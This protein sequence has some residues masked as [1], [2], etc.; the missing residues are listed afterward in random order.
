MKAEQEALVQRVRTALATHPSTREVSMFGTRSFMVDDALVVGALKDGGLL[1][2]VNPDR[3]EELGQVAGASRAE[4]GAGRSMG[5]G[6]LEVAADAL[7]ED[8][9]LTFWLAA[10][11]A[12]QDATTT[13]P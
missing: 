8:E 1:V 4:M 2:R 13:E 5:P 7:H 11:L 9:Q 10:A 12:R 6:W 3:D